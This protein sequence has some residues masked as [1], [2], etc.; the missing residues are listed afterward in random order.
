LLSVS[1]DALGDTPAALAAWMKT[2]GAGPHWRAALPT[3]AGV[4]GIL[5]FLRGRVAGPD[6]HT[7]Q[8]HFFNQRGALVLRSAD[9]P[10]PEQVVSLL[11]RLRSA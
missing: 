2:H 11:T 9:F 8:V 10:P 3:V 1:I 7:G 5:D 6:G 4:D